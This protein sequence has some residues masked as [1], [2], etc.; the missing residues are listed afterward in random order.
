MIHPFF[1]ILACND[2]ITTNSIDTSEPT[3]ISDQ[4]GDGIQDEEDACPNDPLQS[5]D[6][7]GDGFA[8][9]W[10]PAIYRKIKLNS[11]TI[12]QSN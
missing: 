1:M 7:D 10:D 5:T 4:D 12:H 3:T 6:V 2:K 9:E 11:E 8:C